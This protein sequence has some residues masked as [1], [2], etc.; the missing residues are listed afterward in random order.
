M[1]QIQIKPTTDRLLERLLEVIKEQHKQG[2]I[3]D[4]DISNFITLVSNKRKLKQ[5]LLFL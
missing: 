4:T 3:T 1:L 5:A 2:N